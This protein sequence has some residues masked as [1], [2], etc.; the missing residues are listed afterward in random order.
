MD[1]TGRSVRLACI[2]YFTVGDIAKDLPGMVKAGFNCLR[3]PWFNA[4]LDKQ[5]PEMDEIVRT[6]GRIGLKVIFDHH[7]NEV[8]SPEN[9]FL[10]YPCNGLPFDLG[11]GTDNTDGCG[12]AGTITVD[13]FVADW[14]R[15]AARYAGNST[16]IGFDL[17]NEPHFAPLYWKHGGGATWADGGPTDLQAIYQRAGNAILEQ[18]PG[19]L[20][21]CEGVGL[22]KG[23][24]YNGLPLVTNGGTDLTFVPDHSV[25]LSRPSKVV[26][27]VHEYP[28]SIGDG[29]PS[30]GPIKV[31]SM[32]EAWGFLVTR[33]IAPVWIGEMG[34]S[35]DGVGP[36]SQGAK[37]EEERGWATTVIGYLNGACSAA[38]GPSFK[39]GNQ[40]MSSSWWAWG[41]LEGQSPNGTL[42]PDGQLR[43]EQARFYKLLQQVQ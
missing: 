34:A 17:Q 5:L 1:A 35:L 29:R 12:D 32:N 39:P 15:V 19:V 22:F 26:Y 13:R 23:K 2:G 10:P 28:A 30:Y 8:P 18:N 4:T 21:I 43:P 36:D 11:P 3:Y 41:P 31:K 7:G 16:V 6:A 38:G 14:A 25:V 27:S 42:R 9:K 40:A 37:L 24:L 33:D 20:I